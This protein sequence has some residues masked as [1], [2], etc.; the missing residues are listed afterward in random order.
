M[1]KG[2][3]GNV[4]LSHRFTTVSDSD[5]RRARKDE[6]VASRALPVDLKERISKSVLLKSSPLQQPSS[7]S[8]PQQPFSAAVR[9][10]RPQP[11]S[12]CLS[13]ASYCEGWSASYC[14]G[15]WSTI[16]HHVKIILCG[17]LPLKELF[18]YAFGKKNECRKRPGQSY[19]TCMEY[20]RGA[21]SNIRTSLRWPRGLMLPCLA[22]PVQR[23][24][25]EHEA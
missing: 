7:S 5:V 15:W 18:C 14:E 16:P 20:S 23:E 17:N 24:A 13:R 9:S 25:E 22:V 8:L 12:A 2:L 11:F 4:R 1:K 3:P 10:V 21:I 6:K 19:L